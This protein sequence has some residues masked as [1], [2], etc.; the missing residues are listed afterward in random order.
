MRPIPVPV[1]TCAAR[2]ATSA[3]ARGRDGVARPRSG[4][5]LLSAD[6]ERNTRLPRDENEPQNAAGAGVHPAGTDSRAV[7]LVL[8]CNITTRIHL[9]APLSPV[10]VRLRERRG[11][12]QAAAATHD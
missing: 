2:K 9:H 4:M 7:W 5:V 3:I 1:L 8:R 12:T 6:G 11:L 10:A